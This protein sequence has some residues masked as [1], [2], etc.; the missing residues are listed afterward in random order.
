MSLISF[1]DCL[2]PESNI[3]MIRRQKRQGGEWGWMIRLKDRDTAIT[4]TIAPCIV[5]VTPNTSGVRML[6]VSLYSDPEGTPV[7]SVRERPI[8]AWRTEAPVSDDATMDTT[9]IVPDYISASNE[10]WCYFDPASGEYW[11]GEFSVTTREAAIECMLE[12][13]RERQVRA[14]KR[15]AEASA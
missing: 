8:V 1:D 4:D 15:S 14:L 11:D 6:L 10:T 2:I 7:H 3:E 5:S 13:L 9:A 12:D